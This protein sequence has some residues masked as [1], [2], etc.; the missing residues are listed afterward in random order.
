MNSVLGISLK[1]IQIFTSMRK[2]AVTKIEKT[3]TVIQYKSLSHL[4]QR[5]MKH[6]SV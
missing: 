3:I 4:W 6:G 1:T 2:G 5:S